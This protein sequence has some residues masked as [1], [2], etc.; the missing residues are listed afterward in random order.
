ML[1]LLAGW[2]PSQPATASTLGGQGPGFVHRDVLVP[3][4]RPP[5]DDVSCFL[6]DHDRGGVQV[7]ADHAGHDG[8]VDHPEVFHP[9][10]PGLRI[11][12][13]SGVGGLAHLAGARGVVGA[14]RFRPH[15]GVDLFIGLHVA[16]WLELFSP[17]RCQ[18]FLGKN[19]SGQLHTI[20]EIVNV[21]FC[22][23]EDTGERPLITLALQADSGLERLSQLP[24]GR[25]FRTWRSRPPGCSWPIRFLPSPQSHREHARW[26]QLASEAASVNKGSGLYLHIRNRN[27]HLASATVWL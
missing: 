5:P 20:A 1:A 14:V 2:G 11:H 24:E 17:E 27:T 8:C 4:C 10:H 26:T 3:E 9:N 7:A 18:G 6:R 16:S 12:H 15:K 22:G 21:G 25:R 13:G 19:F 23:G